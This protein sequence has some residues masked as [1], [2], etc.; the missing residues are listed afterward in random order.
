MS[1]RGLIWTGGISAV[2]AGVVF[3]VVDAWDFVNFL[4][5]GDSVP[6]SEVVASTEWMVSSVAYLVGGLLLM[7]ALVGLYARQADEAGTFGIVGF[8]AALVGTGMVMGVMWASLFVAPS[9]AIEAPAFLDNQNPAGPLNAGFIVSG[10]AVALGW[11]VFGVATF[12]ARVYPRAAAIVLTVGALI[13][14]APLPGTVMLMDVALIWLGAITVRS[15]ASAPSAEAV[16][17]QPQA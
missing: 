10:L 8:V 11:A 1:G 7:V 12:R 9:L 2:V 16:E 14:F 3:L 4:M 6:F 5:Y 17:A 13:S 15:L